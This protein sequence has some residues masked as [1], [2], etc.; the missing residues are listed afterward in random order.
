MKTSREQ[1]GKGV[2]WELLGLTVTGTCLIWEKIMSWLRDGVAT[3]GTVPSVLPILCSVAFGTAKGQ[4]S[5]CLCFMS[6]VGG[7]L[8]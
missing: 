3:S 4:V 1:K 2:L 7:F 8:D 6:L 5:F